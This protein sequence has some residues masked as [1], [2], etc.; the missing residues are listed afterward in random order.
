MKKSSIFIINPKPLQK[1]DLKFNLLGILDKSWVTTEWGSIAD[2]IGLEYLDIEGKSFIGKMLFIR[3]S[4]GIF[5]WLTKTYEFGQVEDLSDM[6]WSIQ[7]SQ[8]RITLKIFN[9]WDANSHTLY[10]PIIIKQF[11]TNVDDPELESRHVGIADKIRKFDQALKS[12]NRELESLNHKEQE[13]FQLN[14]AE[15]SEEWKE[16]ENEKLVNDI[17]WLLIS[18][19]SDEKRTLDEKYKEA[20]DW[21]G[22]LFKGTAGRLNG[23]SFKVYSDDHGRHFH[24]VHRER[25]IDARFSFPDIQLLN[26][27][28]SKNLIG[29]KEVENIRQYFNI[30]E[31]FQKLENEFK[32]RESN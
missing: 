5:G 20:L 19:E 32:K 26:Y 2:S 8:G 9:Q 11:A 4:K 27:K 7:E 23:F 21:R 29:S 18:G 25:N 16:I 28:N 22:P 30:P 24:V 6:A 31:H 10:I 13:E 17:N 3:R 12:Y 15:D 1:V 14:L